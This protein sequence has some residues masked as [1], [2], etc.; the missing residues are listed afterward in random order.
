MGMT[1]SQLDHLDEIAAEVKET[2]VMDR[3][4]ATSTGEGLYIAL[5]SNSSALL[6][7]LGYSIPEA[8]SRLGAD[9]LASLVAR[10]QYRR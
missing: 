6:A 7:E 5:A 8:L 3:V 4:W 9:D 2:G 10:W 1:N